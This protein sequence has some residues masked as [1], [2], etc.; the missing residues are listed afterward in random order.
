M[1]VGV[2]LTSLKNRGKWASF[3]WTAWRFLLNTALE[4]GWTPKGTVLELTEKKK[5]RKKSSG[6]KL[7][8]TT[9]NE[10]YTRGGY[11]SND[12]QTVTT[13][14]AVNLLRALKRA[15]DTSTFVEKTSKDDLKMIRDFGKFLINGAFRID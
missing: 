9:Q 7:A 8:Q 11:A 15:L 14:D 5:S 4:Y 6:A 13:E 3:N 10:E 1:P 2:D 12:G